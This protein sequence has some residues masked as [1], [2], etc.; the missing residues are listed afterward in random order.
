MSLDTTMTVAKMIRNTATKY[1]Q[2]IAQYKRNKNGEFEEITYAEMLQ[3]GL[4][5]GAALLQHGIKRGDLI[6]MISD[7]RAEWQ[8]ADIGIM[9][10]GAI[11]VPRGCDATLIDLEKILSIPECKVV[12]VENSAQINKMLSLQEKLPF[13]FGFLIMYLI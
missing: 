5:F 3:F 10:V 8:Q 9:A 11:D 7:N 1:P 4:D 13:F 6:G 12:I 2:V